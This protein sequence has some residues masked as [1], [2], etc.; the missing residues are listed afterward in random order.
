M[1]Q[2]FVSW[3]GVTLARDGA[4]VR[5]LAPACTMVSRWPSVSSRNQTPPLTATHTCKRGLTMFGVETT[6]F[7][8]GMY[9]LL[10]S[11]LAFTLSHYVPC[12]YLRLL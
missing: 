12:V 5:Q 3:S 4:S 6:I 2:I 7:Q 9:D 11:F 10:V 8:E 1:R